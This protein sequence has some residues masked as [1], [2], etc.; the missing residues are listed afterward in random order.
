ME[1]ESKMYRYIA[2]I[3]SLLLLSGLLISCKSV[4]QFNNIETPAVEMERYNDPNNYYSIQYPKDWE[5]MQLSERTFLTQILN[6]SGGMRSMV[7]ISAGTPSDFGIDMDIED[8]V[9]KLVSGI[10]KE[11]GQMRAV[12]FKGNKAFEYNIRNKEG[13]YPYVTQ[14]VVYTDEYLYNVLGVFADID[15]KKIGEYV[16]SSLELK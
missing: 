12:N 13:P 8:Y 1:M 7:N 3:T 15:D 14:L 6:E 4:S 5:Y 2:L 11:M 10:E 9:R 16:I